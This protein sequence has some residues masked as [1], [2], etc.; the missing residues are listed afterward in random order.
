MSSVGDRHL[1]SNAELTSEAI[2]KNK[3]HKPP[4]VFPNLGFKA[5]L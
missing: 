2:K 3:N 1:A 4:N 5:V